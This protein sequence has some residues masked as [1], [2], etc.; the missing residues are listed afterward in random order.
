MIKTLRGDQGTWHEGYPTIQ[1]IGYGG[2]DDYSPNWLSDEGIRG[3]QGLKEFNDTHSL[4]DMI[5]YR[6]SSADSFDVGDNDFLEVMEHLLHTIHLFGVAGGVEGSSEALYLEAVENPN[7]D[8][9]PLHLAMKEAI[10]NGMYSPDYSPE[11]NQS[12][13]GAGVAYKEYLYLLNFNM[14]EMSEFW[15]G[16]SLALEWN[17]SMRTPHGIMTNNPLGYDLFIQ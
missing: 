16:K 6:N 15:E 7:W 9:T 4:N 10:N 11:W 5:W 1:R 13:D 8:S 14:W 12:E 17:D 3:Y 2:G